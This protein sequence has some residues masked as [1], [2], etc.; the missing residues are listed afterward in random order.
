MKDKGLAHMGVGYGK[1]D[2]KAQDA[3]DKQY[4]LHY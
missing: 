2:N 4:H 1:G 3:L